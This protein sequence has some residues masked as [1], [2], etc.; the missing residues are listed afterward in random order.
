MTAVKANALA[1]VPGNEVWML[2]ADNSGKRV[3][4][5]SPKVRIVDLGVDY[6]KDDYIIKCVQSIIPYKYFCIKKIYNSS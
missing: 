1:E 6:Y 5:V 2:V 4:E 3:F